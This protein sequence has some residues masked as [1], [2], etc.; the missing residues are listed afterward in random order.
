[1]T[2]ANA[3]VIANI[4]L[5]PPQRPSIFSISPLRYRFL[6]IFDCVIS[7]ISNKSIECKILNKNNNTSEGNV[8]IDVFQGLPKFDKMEL[9]IQK[10][11]ELGV[12]SFTPVNFNRCI[13]KIDK[14]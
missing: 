13:V 11:T 2:L 9:I 4:R 6:H 10:G 5:Y 12:T 3:L 1:M 14:K 8:K 7:S